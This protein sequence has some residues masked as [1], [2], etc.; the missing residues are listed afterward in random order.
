MIY[1]LSRSNASTFPHQRFLSDWAVMARTTPFQDAHGERS[2]VQL[3]SV[4]SW[5]R[6]ANGS[7]LLP[8]NRASEIGSRWDEVTLDGNVTENYGETALIS[9]ATSLHRLDHSINTGNCAEGIGRLLYDRSLNSAADRP[10][11]HPQRIRQSGASSTP[12]TPTMMRRQ[13]GLDSASIPPRQSH[14]VRCP[15]KCR[16]KKSHMSRLRSRRTASRNTRAEFR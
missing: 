6:Y 1:A 13:T 8:T 10:Q 3:R 9:L 14:G 15:M 5:K 2:S 11:L 12:A 16:T 4:A 7:S